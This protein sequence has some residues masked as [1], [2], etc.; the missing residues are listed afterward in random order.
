MNTVPAMGKMNKKIQNLI[1]LYE[2][3]RDRRLPRLL[4][5]W[6]GRLPY[7]VSVEAGFTRYASCSSIEE[8]FQANLYD[9]EKTLACPSDTL[10]NLEPWFG[11]GLFAEAFGCRYF[12]REGDAP[13]VHYA[14]HTIDEI[15]EIT[16]PDIS[17]GKIFALILAAIAYFKERTQGRLPMCLTDTQSASDTA[18]LIL[19]ASEF[20]IACYTDPGIAHRFL[21]IINDLTIEFSRKQAEAIGDCLVLPGRIIAASLPASQGGTG[22]TI[23]DDNLAVAS[24]KINAEFFLPL[25]DQI[26][27]AFGGAAIHSCGNWGHTIPLL[28][29]WKNLTMIECKISS[30]MDP[31][32]TPPQQ[33]REALQGTGIAVQVT[34]NTDVERDFDLLDRLAAPGLP[35]I[36]RFLND[37]TGDIQSR[38][39]LVNRRLQKIYG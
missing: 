9:F 11:T 3:A 32:P 15:R 1:D 18:T 6:Q 26:G 2:A 27:Q 28:R 36:V 39:D 25:D 5:F 38:Y 22:I 21:Q 30:P 20:F 16:K 33:V 35:L 4:D 17:S 8:N 34:L 31:N 19:D 7:L 23:A 29:R 12:W 10:P 37:G 24:P 14:Y 13:A